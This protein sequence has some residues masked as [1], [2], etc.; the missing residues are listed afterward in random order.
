MNEQQPLLTAS[1]ED[2][3]ISLLDL[4]QVVVDNLRLLVIGP[5]VAGLAALGISFLIQP[6]F[7]AT[8]TFLPPQ[9]QQSSAAAMLQSLGALS[10]VAGAAAGLKNP[11]DQY[12]AFTK[13]NS[14]ANAL[15][16]RF[17]L[18]NRYEQNR[19][20]LTQEV[21]EKRTKVTSG[22]D[23]LI[24]LEVEDH[25]P[26]FAADLANAYVE[27]L[28]KLMDR[29]AVTEAQQRR[30]FFKDKLQEAKDSLTKAQ[31]ALAGTGVAEGVVRMNP[32]AAVGQVATLMARVAAKE[33]ELG[34]MRNYLTSESPEFKRAQSE[35]AALRA[36][37]NKAEQNSVA[38]GGKDDYVNKFRDFKYY[39]TLFEL[40]A[41]QYEIA[42]IDEAREG[43]VIQVVDRALP[44]EWKTK[45]KEPLIAVL[46][47]LAAGFLLLIVVFV[48]SA[49]ANA[50]QDGETAQKLALIRLGFRRA[51]GRT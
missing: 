26:Q 51:L 49:L 33:V 34:A 31:Q 30:A 2:D 43:A 42:R 21:L 38:G 47:T 27:E 50:A 12:V 18:Q 39:E 46:V 40:M 20:E 37:L 9:Q 35:L 4:L 5:I 8:T 36:Q 6:T 48:R 19:R 41:K 14:V 24:R 23:G 44:P 29:L 1:A 7:T 22:K 10:G 11:A 15:I 3:E 32:E 25:E 13:S 16:D 17:D 28:G 45:P